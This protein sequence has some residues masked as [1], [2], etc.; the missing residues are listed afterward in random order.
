MP[1]R[2]VYRDGVLYKLEWYDP[3]LHVWRPARTLYETAEHAAQIAR[4]APEKQWRLM[5]VS[6]HGYRPMTLP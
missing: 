2:R 6:A 1:R 3:D 4:T 5:E